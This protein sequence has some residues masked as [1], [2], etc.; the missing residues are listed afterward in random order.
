MMTDGGGEMLIEEIK[1]GDFH[2]TVMIGDQRF[3]CG[4]YLNRA[5]AAQAGRLF[6]ERKRGEQEGQKKRPRKKRPG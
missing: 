2:L 4:S 3:D 6:I 1:A 5:A